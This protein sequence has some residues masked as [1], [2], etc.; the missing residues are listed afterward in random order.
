[1][2]RILVLAATFAVLVSAIDFGGSSSESCEDDGH[3]HGHGNGN[4][5]GGANRGCDAGWKRFNRPAG[6]WCM[7]SF[8]GILSRDSAEAQCQTLGATLSGFQSFAEAQWV[9]TSAVSVIKRPSGYLWIGARPSGY[10]WIGARSPLPSSGLMPSRREP[11]VSTGTIS[12]LTTRILI[13]H[14][15][16]S[17]PPTHQS[18]SRA[19]SSSRR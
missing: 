18:T 13:N 15:P 6:G 3:G 8:G 4:G 11:P 16:L 2:L 9:S 14:A 1:M 17:W 5:N 12:N 7:R 19:I 10:L